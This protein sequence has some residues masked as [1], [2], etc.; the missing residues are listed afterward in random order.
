[1]ASLN[2][3]SFIG[4]LGADPEVRNFQSGGRV[5]NLRLA[6]SE[7]WKDKNTGERKER[8]E[9]VGVA[10]FSEGLI[11]VAEK[12]LRKGSKIFVQGQWRTRKY[13]AQDGNDRYVTECVLQGPGAILTMLESRDAGAKEAQPDKYPSHQ[14]NGSRGHAQSTADDLDSDIP[15]LRGDGIW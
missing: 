8:T 15:F 9:W 7:S 4:N 12:Y 1:M 5:C 3:C 10:I 11:G 6:C 2:Q 13:Q 14:P